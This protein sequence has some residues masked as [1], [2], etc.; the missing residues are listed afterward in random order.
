MQFLDVPLLLINNKM[1]KIYHIC[2]KCKE[3]KETRRFSIRYQDFKKTYTRG[4]WRD[5]T[6]GRPYKKM[7]MYHTKNMD[8]CSPCIH[9]LIKSI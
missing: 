6:E 7:W 2:E 1:S 8:V 5:N 4:N 3:K 9:K